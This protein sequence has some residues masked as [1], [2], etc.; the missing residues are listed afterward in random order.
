MNSGELAADGD[1]AVQRVTLFGD[2]SGDGTYSAL[3]AS[4]VARVA[5]GLDS[6][7]DA[8]NLIDPIILADVTG[9][10]TL[11]AL[12]ASFIARKAVGLNQPEMPDLHAPLPPPPDASTDTSAFGMLTFS[13][14][15]RRNEGDASLAAQRDA[16]FRSPQETVYAYIV[17]QQDLQTQKFSSSVMS[18]IIAARP[19]GSKADLEDDELDSLIA[20]LALD[21]LKM[22]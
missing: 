11:S 17:L 12:D 8:A 20:S 1:D 21:W 3:D 9:D 7:F 2:A 15:E 4:L 5:V 18:S 6:G 10:G 22:R 14:D 13:P 19:D 16:A